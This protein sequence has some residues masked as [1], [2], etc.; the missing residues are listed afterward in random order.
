VIY[1]HFSDVGNQT[2]A[3]FCQENQRNNR[4]MIIYYS[5]ASYVH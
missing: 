3:A 2:I 4:E 1:R 5:A